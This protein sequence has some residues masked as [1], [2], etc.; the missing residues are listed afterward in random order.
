MQ[1][2][3][4]CADANGVSW[5]DLMNRE[6]GRAPGHPRRKGGWGM[7]PSQLNRARLVGE[8]ERELVLHPSQ[9]ELVAVEAVH[10]D[11]Q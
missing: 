10:E 4:N 1:I 9:V 11:V 7:L 5:A 6:G 2:D 3:K 8:E